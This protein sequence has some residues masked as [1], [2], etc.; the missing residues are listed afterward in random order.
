MI[1]G[2]IAF[3]WTKPYILSALV[4][5]HYISISPTERGVWWVIRIFT[6]GIVRMRDWPCSC[7]FVLNEAVRRG[8][9]GQYSSKP[10]QD[11]PVTGTESEN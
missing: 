5:L 4:T 3:L 9:I 2:L 6:R 8:K 7:M 11:L 1:I 10:G